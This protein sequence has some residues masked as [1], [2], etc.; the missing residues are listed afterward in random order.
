VQYVESLELLVAADDVR[1][2]VALGV[3]DMKTGAGWIGEHVEAVELGLGGIEARL[4]GVGLA[5][6][7][8]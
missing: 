6:S 3:A 1:S 5:E 7:L 2:C 8:I 4:A